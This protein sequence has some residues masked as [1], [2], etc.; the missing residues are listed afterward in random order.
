VVAT[1]SAFGGVLAAALL[2]PGVV[3]P[4]AHAETAPE[5]GMVALKLSNYRDWQ[6][7]LERIKVD[8]P[9]LYMLAPLDAHW[10]LEASLV[11]DAV[12]G[13]SPRYHSA[14]SGASKMDDSRKRFCNA[15]PPCSRSIARHRASRCARRLLQCPLAPHNRS[16]AAMTT[17]YGRN[18]RK[19]LIQTLYRWIHRWNCEVRQ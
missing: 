7:G 15:R 1:E 2:L 13:A 10:S 18:S 17:R 6:P 9:S 19:R 4:A 8:A 12:S 16:S 11:N 3:A 14:I 5:Q